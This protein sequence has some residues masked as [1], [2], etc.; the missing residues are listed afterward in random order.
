MFPTHESNHISFS[1]HLCTLDC[2]HKVS[3]G[4]SVAALHRGRPPEPAVKNVDPPSVGV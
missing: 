2:S 4:S 1:C 3:C